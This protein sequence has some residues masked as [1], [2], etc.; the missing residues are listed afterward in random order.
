MDFRMGVFK[1]PKNFISKSLTH[2]SYFIKIEDDWF[3]FFKTWQDSSSLRTGNINTTY[4]KKTNFD[5][6]FIETWFFRVN[7]ESTKNIVKMSL[8]IKS[9]TKL[10][11]STSVDILRFFY[12]YVINE[13]I[14]A[15]PKPKTVKDKYICNL[16]GKKYAFSRM[17]VGSGSCLTF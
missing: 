6:C 3:V 5:F 9:Y 4:Y 16:R 1:Y 13:I 8:W 11:T 10:D 15:Q 17:R 12:K 14:D 2:S 7:Y